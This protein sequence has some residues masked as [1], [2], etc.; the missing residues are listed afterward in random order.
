MLLS[1]DLFIES[2]RTETFIALDASILVGTFKKVF[3]IAKRPQAGKKYSC[4]ANREL[5]DDA[6]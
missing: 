5:C 3:K 1:K 2:D 4:H 6:G